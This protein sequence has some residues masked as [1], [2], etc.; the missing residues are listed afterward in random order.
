MWQKALE[1]ELGD[2]VL[3]RTLAPTSTVAVNLIYK[4]WGKKIKAS[5]STL[6]PKSEMLDFHSNSDRNLLSL[7]KNL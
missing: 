5:N 2:P 7:L 1:H 3:A 6:Q 4:I